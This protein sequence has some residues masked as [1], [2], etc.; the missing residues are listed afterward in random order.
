MAQHGNTL[1]KYKAV[2]EY[3][4][5]VTF[6]HCLREPVFV[7]WQ[8]SWTLWGVFFF[9]TRPF[10]KLPGPMCVQL[11]CSGSTSLLPAPTCNAI[12]LRRSVALS[13]W[14]RGKRSAALWKLHR[15]GKLVS[16]IKMRT[17]CQQ[18]TEPGI[19]WD[20]ARWCSFSLTVDS[21]IQVLCQSAGLP[22]A[23]GCVARYRWWGFNFH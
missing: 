2:P 14:G 10:E 7:L 20:V 11:W 13:R 15:I 6:H 4:Y 12:T 16:D 22:E 8:W 1:F 9:S 3:V 19:V 5:M 18:E 23:V 17:E 21:L